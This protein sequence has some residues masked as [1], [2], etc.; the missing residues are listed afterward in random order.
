MVCS[1][2]WL[3]N[4]DKVK[5]LIEDINIVDVSIKCRW[6]WIILEVLKPYKSIRITEMLGYPNSKLL[7]KRYLVLEPLSRMHKYL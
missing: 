5:Q 4:S 6:I 3:C 1:V 2:A 7:G